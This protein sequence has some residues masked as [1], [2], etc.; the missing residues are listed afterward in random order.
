MGL[1]EGIRLKGQV[2]VEFLE[3]CFDGIRNG[4]AMKAGEDGVVSNKLGSVKDIAQYFGLEP[5]CY[6]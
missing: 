1:K 5:L 2:G 3:S 6:I 4:G